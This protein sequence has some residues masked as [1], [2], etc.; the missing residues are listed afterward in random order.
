MMMLRMDQQLAMKRSFE[1]LEMAY[2]KEMVVEMG[3]PKTGRLFIGKEDEDPTAV[4]TEAERRLQA[5]LEP[6][7]EEPLCVGTEEGRVLKVH[8]KQLMILEDALVGFIQTGQATVEQVRWNVQKELFAH[9]PEGGWGARKEG[10][11]LG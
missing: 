11:W 4:V 3:A 9:K 6:G 10:C 8:Q 2:L 5:L 7:T 1:H